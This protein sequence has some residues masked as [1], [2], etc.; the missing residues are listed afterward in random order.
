MLKRCVNILKH[1]HVS[2]VTF[3][4]ILYL[5]LYKPAGKSAI[6]MFANMDKVAHFM[7]YATFSAVLWYEYCHCH[8]RINYFRLLLSSFLAPA[9]LSWIM[10]ILQE[11]LTKYRSGDPMDLLFNVL[12]I[13]FANILCLTLGKCLLGK[14]SRKK[15]TRSA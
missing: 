10:E 14:R 3:C 1:Y 15:E 2:I 12:G 5:S 7:M 11:K 9:L 4:V 8:H 13:I 6:M